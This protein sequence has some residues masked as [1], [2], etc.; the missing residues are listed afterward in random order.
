MASVDLARYT[1]LAVNAAKRSDGL[2]RFGAVLFSRGNG[3]VLGNGHSS[4]CTGR[5]LSSEW[6]IHAEAAALRAAIKKNGWN[7]HRPWGMVIVRI[8]D[9]DAIMPAKP[10]AACSALISW[11]DVEAYWT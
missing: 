8:N 5:P 3:Y 2:F 4:H 6:T 10:C 9:K 7:A 1:R 11:A